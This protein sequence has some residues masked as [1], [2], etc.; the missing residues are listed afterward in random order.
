MA[1]KKSTG[2]S[3]VFVDYRSKLEHYIRSIVSPQD[4]DDIVQ[5][6]FVRTYE[7]HLKKDIR[8][9]RT[10]MLRTVRNIALNHVKRWDNKYGTSIEDLSEPLVHF[11]TASLEAQLESEERFLDFCRAVDKLSG[12]CKKAFI[13]KKVYGLSQ[14]EIAQYLKISEST[15]EKHVAKGMLKTLEYMKN[16]EETTNERR[17]SQNSDAPHLKK[18]R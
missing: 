13:L 16:L 4:I 10:F 11:Q 8:Y 18:I 17:E 12:Q 7:A 9:P 2:L 5:E 15:V 3:R 6:T 1:N 14:K